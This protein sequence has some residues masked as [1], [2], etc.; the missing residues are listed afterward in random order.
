MTGRSYPMRYNRR[1]AQQPTTCALG[2]WPG[3]TNGPRQAMAGASLSPYIE[4]TVKIPMGYRI[5]E[6]WL[7]G[8]LKTSVSPRRH[9]PPIVRKTGLRE[10][11]RGALGPQNSPELVFAYSGAGT[12]A[13]PKMRPQPSS[14]NWVPSGTSVS[15]SKSSLNPSGSVSDVSHMPLLTNGRD[16]TSPRA[17]TC[18]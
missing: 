17:C 15:L 14:P 4:A 16:A 13:D 5:I 2:A 11:G 8:L 18:S 6:E 1:V 7:V 12:V 3:S 10:N 9:P